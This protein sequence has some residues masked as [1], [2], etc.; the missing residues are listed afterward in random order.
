MTGID[1]DYHAQLFA[2]G[3]AICVDAFVSEYMIMKRA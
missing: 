2:A 3:T 1:R